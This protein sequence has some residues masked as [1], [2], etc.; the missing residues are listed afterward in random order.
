[1]I[2]RALEVRR[3]QKVRELEQH[4]DSMAGQVVPGT[5]TEEM[6]AAFS[7]ALNHVRQR[8]TCQPS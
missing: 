7:E 5:N 2:T 8:R 6:E 4:L 1:V 3:R